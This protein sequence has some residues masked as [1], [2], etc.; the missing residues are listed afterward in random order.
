MKMTLFSNID[1][2]CEFI[3]RILLV[4]LFFVFF[5]FLVFF[6]VFFFHFHGLFS[7]KLFMCRN[8]VPFFRHFVTIT[9]AMLSG[10]LLLFV[11]SRLCIFILPHLQTLLAFALSLVLSCKAKLTKIATPRCS[12]LLSELN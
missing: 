11:K 10:K 5:L 6:F 7:L 3:F 9:F 8:Y 12:C 2:Y 4:C 1:F